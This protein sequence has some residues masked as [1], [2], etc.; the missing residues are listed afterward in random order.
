MKVKFFKATAF[1]VAGL[2]A[3]SGVYAQEAAA[4]EVPAGP[5]PQEIAAQ[6]MDELL[7]LVK[8][9]RA[10]A[11]AENRAREQRFQ[12]DKA[13]QQAALIVLAANVLQKSVARHGLKSSSRTTNC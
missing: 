3:S 1:A 5:T 2:I 7:D 10:R 13:N 12:Q 4:P 6:N 8:Q 9:G 11:A